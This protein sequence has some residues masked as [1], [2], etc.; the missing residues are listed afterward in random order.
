M[1]QN[2]EQ[3]EQS[4]IFQ[5]SMED[6]LAHLDTVQAQLRAE[7]EKAIDMQ[8]AAKEEHNRIL[9]EAEKI[10][11]EKI[12]ADYKANL[13][14]LRTEVWKDTLKKLIL[15]EIPSDM[16]KKILEI[17]A[18]ILADIWYELGFDKVG[19]NHVGHVTYQNEGRYGYVI[20]LRND[21]SARFYYEFGGGDAVAI[22]TVPTAEHWE[23][24]TKIPL[25][26]RAAIL[27]FI[28]V[29]VLRDQAPNCKYFIGESD[30]IIMRN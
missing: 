7:Q 8:I 1:D 20:F 4:K 16:L 26:D 27:E 2:P 6:A 30:I 18:K 17:P 10:A 29:R 5:K 11:Q 12:E 19:D 22:I 25:A 14:K 21:I 28:A 9:R 13:E 3:S 23:K 15:A 24:E